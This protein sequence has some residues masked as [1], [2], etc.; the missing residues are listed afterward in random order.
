MNEWIDTR[1]MEPTKDGMYLVQ[2]AHG[3]LEG[4]SF[5]VDGGWNTS[6]DYKGNL[7]DK[8]AIHRANVA[9]WFDAPT[10]PEVPDAWFAEAIATMTRG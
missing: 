5:T 6:Y 4:L 9:R 1:K 8:N 7:S 2:M 3:G 10:P